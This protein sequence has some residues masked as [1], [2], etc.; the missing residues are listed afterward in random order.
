M[1]R[2]TKKELEQIN[3]LLEKLKRSSD[4]VIPVDF[5]KNLEIKN[6]KPSYQSQ[7]FF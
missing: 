1:R 6:V 7:F 3:K 2:N 4:I 5:Y